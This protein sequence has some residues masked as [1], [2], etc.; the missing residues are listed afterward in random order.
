MLVRTVRV[1]VSHRVSKRVLEQVLDRRDTQIKMKKKQ[2]S[3]L[4]IK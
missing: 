3:N 2:K 1:R 4:V